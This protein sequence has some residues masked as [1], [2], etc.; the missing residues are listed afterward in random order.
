MN[1]RFDPAD[2]F[3][4]VVAFPPRDRGES[5]ML[6]VDV[7][8]FEGPLDLLLTLARA[9]KVDLAR[10]S[11]LALVE[12]YLAFV[13]TARGLRLDLAADYLVMAA[14]LAFLKSR[15]LLPEPESHEDEPSAEEMA[16]ALAERLRKLEAMREA[17]ARLARLA[18]LGR[19][20]FERGMPEGVRRLRGSAFEGTLHDLLRAYADGRRRE[21]VQSQMVVRRRSVL[22][23]AEARAIL[24]RLIGGQAAWCPF[25]DLVSAYRTDLV[26]R[27][28]VLAS[29]FAASLELVREGRMEMRQDAPFGALHVRAGSAAG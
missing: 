16:F 19:E 4:N 21:I 27:G 28:S 15:L 23:L 8:G 20:I 9:Q 12:Q 26:S 14:W 25:E 11:V 2:T 6:I 1:E 13:E 3:E 29:G 17:A 7:A 22:S 24:E 10:I 18:R 5:E